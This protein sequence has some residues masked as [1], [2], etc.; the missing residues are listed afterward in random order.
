MSNFKYDANMFID[1]NK[2]GT[3][4]AT[5]PAQF[6]TPPEIEIDFG[7]IFDENSTVTQIVN[8]QPMLVKWTNSE[9]VEGSNF[10]YIDFYNEK[11]YDILSK[12]CQ[13]SLIVKTI[14]NIIQT[15][16]RNILNI[17]TPETIVKEASEM[18]S[19]IFEGEIPCPND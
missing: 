15:K 18:M 7:P 4:P 13:D 2:M 19:N 5:E 14:S 10:F 16:K 8:L 17:P 12:E 1:C 3:L 6:G 11:V 9:G